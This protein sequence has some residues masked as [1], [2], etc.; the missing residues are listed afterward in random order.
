MFV[1]DKACS[2]A[3]LTGDDTTGLDQDCLPGDVPPAS[4]SSERDAAFKTAAACRQK[5]AELQYLGQTKKELAVLKAQ[6]Q[7]L[8]DVLHPRHLQLQEARATALNVALAANDVKS[9]FVEKIDDGSCVFV[10]F[11]SVLLRC[12]IIGDVE[13]AV[14]CLWF[15]LKVSDARWDA[16]FQSI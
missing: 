10:C 3:V 8:S 1:W 12:V 4:A 6:A 11:C 2:G 16:S 7:V 5:A 9:A 15:K 13:P 14:R